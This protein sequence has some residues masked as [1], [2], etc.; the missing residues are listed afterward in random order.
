MG[1]E[2][3]AHAAAAHVPLTALNHGDG[4]ITDPAAVARAVAAA[5][6]S[7]IVNAAAY[8]NVDDAEADEAAAL[9]VNAE[10]PAVLAEAAM[11]ADVPL[12]H[13]STDYVF[14]G[15]K[16]AAYVETDRVNPLNVYGRSK[17]AGEDAVRRIAP[18]HFILRTAWLFS[19]HGANFVKTM[20]R[21]AADRAEVRAA[22]DQIGSPTGVGDLADAILTLARGGQRPWGTYHVAGAPAS[23]HEWAA[24]VVAAQARF[25]GRNPPVRA[26]S[27]SAFPAAARRP[28]NSSL[29]SSKFA[30][31]FD[32]EV[33]DWRDAV[34]RTVAALFAERVEP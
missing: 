34:N 32:F 28:R 1:R 14:D 31:T 15:E 5:A 30:K 25:T 12:V 20:V 7:L 2:L 9:R 17:A 16:G 26:V 22:A 11:R 19:T 13:L 18:R 23:R 29:D 33:T 21:A 27:A 4:D 8:N 3:V 6:P 24:A 10:G